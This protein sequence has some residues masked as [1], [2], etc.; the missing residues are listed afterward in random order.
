MP[1]S[2]ARAATFAAPLSSAMTEF[3]IDTPQR[4]AA[5]LAQLCHESG[6]LRY[7]RELA[8]G[9]A[10]EGRLDLGNIKP[11]DGVRFKGRG[12]IQIT[13]RSNYGKCGQALNV[14]YIATPELLER[15][16]DA[17]RSAGW[18][19]SSRGLNTLADSDSFGMLTKKINGGFT[20]LDD[21]IHHWLRARKALGVT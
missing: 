7:V 13:G 3:K 16:L 6:S 18:F 2:G 12:L 14:D 19:W 11:G 1:A 5:F 15:P 21:R 8:S 9:E 10:Y 4:Q 17:C 20:G